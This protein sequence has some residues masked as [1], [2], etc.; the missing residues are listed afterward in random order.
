MTKRLN[1][2]IFLVVIVMALSFTACT[3]PEG[4][5]Y[6]L[7]EAYDNGWLTTEDLKSTAFYY[8]GDADTGFVAKPKNPETLSAETE[9]AIKQAYLEVLKERKPEATIDN[10]WIA[11]YYGTYGDV[12][13]VKVWDD[14]FMY[15]LIFIP[16][17]T[18][19]GVLFRNYSEREVYVWKAA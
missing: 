10:V 15:D 7:N 4:S 3:K 19:G 1:R 9:S 6:T 14:C 11:E 18:I 12:V 16:E 2:I 5:F 13:V 8:R 17:V